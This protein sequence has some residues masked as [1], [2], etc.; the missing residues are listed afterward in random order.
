MIGLGVKV[1]FAR[2]IKSARDFG[3][4]VSGIPFVSALFLA[5]AA[6]KRVG[7]QGRPAQPFRGYPGVATGIWKGRD[8]QMRERTMSRPRVVSP[9]Y[10][11]IGGKITKSGARAFESSQALHSGTRPGSFWVTGGM[12]GGLST[13]VSGSRVARN[14]F[15]GRSEGQGMSLGRSSNEP[16]FDSSGRPRPKKVSN[17]LK[18]AT[19]LRATGV[20]VLAIVDEELRQVNAGVVEMAAWGV[21]DAMLADV[22]FHTRARGALASALSAHGIF[23]TRGATAVAGGGV[24]GG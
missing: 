11:V 6:K 1:E 18:A 24:F 21:R 19:V 22:T 7:Q 4:A 3:A 12:W 8:H 13:V 16:F 2:R 23:G 9:R 15:R 10:P 5:R 17:A 20:N 14:L